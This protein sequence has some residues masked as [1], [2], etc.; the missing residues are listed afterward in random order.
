MIKVDRLA[1]GTLLI[2]S[3]IGLVKVVNDQLFQRRLQIPPANANQGPVGGVQFYCEKYESFFS[4]LR[5]CNNIKLNGTVAR[6]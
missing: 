2:P 6:D 1:A 3:C 4:E 5:A